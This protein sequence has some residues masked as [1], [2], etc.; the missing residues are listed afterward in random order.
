[1]AMQM[2]MV[3]EPPVI[4]APP[5]TRVQRGRLGQIAGLAAE[6]IVARHYARRG[7]VVAHRRWR[8]A[9]GEID[10]VAREADRVVF[11][12]V[13]KSRCFDR[14]AGA[15]G[16]R[17]MARIC[18]TAEEFLGGEPLGL[19]TEMRIDLALVDGCGSV[20]IIEN[21]FGGD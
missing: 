8:G 6:D 16:P 12:E 7:G 14:A 3:L 2:E 4:P 21:A 13:K 20:R 15:L 11:I 19:L 1:M 17:Q 9:G 18:R 10:L 5:E